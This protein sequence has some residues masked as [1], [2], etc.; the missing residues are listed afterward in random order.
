M[1]PRKCQ[2]GQALIETALTLPLLLTLLLGAAELAR[3]VYVSIEVSNAAEA[4]A[5]YAAQNRGASTA[6]MQTVA[7][8]DAGD[9]DNATSLTLTATSSCV[10]ETSTGGMAVACTSDAATACVANA[11]TNMSLQTNITVVTSATFD[12]L[13]HIPGLPRAFTIQGQSVQKVLN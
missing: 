4:A 12:P 11:Q 7:Q 6:D 10:C 13:I 3:V 5:L 2:S 8:N 1:N 9:L